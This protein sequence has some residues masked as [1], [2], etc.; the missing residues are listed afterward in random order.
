MFNDGLFCVRIEIS[1]KSP[2]DVCCGV[3]ENMAHI[4]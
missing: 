2:S 3:A 4:G 1:D